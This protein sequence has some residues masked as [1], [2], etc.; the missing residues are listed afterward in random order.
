MNNVTRQRIHKIL[1]PA[2][3]CGMYAANLGHRCNCHVSHVHRL[4][5]VSAVNAVLPAFGCLVD[6]DEAAFC[7][8]HDVPLHS[9]VFLMLT[10]AIKR[11]MRGWIGGCDAARQVSSE[12]RDIS[13]ICR[14]AR[15]GGCPSCNASSNV[16]VEC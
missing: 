5:S 4:F 13:W 8:A 7:A 14:G 9:T 12:I 10:A 11:V 16:K 3:T 6:L 2:R 1:P 15:A